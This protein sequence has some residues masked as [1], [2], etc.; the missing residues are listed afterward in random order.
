MELPVGQ[1]SIELLEGWQVR[2]LK[3][4]GSYAAVAAT[5][6]PPNPRPLEV[7]ER[8]EIDVRLTFKTEFEADPDAIELGFGRVNVGFEVVEESPCAGPSCE[9]PC[10]GPSCE[11]EVAAYPSDRVL[12]PISASV[13]TAL[14]AIEERAGHARDVFMK[15]GET[16][17]SIANHLR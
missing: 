7:L 11:F 14:K 3:P 9:G 15:A 13:A 6:V 8:Q 10:T 17:Q 1:Y 2:R 4:N 12:S 5:L 16:P